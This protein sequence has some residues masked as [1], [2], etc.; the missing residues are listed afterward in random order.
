LKSPYLQLLKKRRSEDKLLEDEQVKA[1]YVDER[2]RKHFKMKKIYIFGKEKQNIEQYS[3]QDYSTHIRR[4]KLTTQMMMGC[5][6]MMELS[7][8]NQN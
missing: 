6:H 2:K 7:Y 3:I 5:K 4:T 1:N 8:L